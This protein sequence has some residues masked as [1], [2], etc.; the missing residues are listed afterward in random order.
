MSD[1][2]Q[3]VEIIVSAN[4]SV[5]E[6][7]AGPQGPP[8][9]D[10]WLEPVQPLTATG[11]S[12]LIDYSAGKHVRLTLSS[13]VTLAISNWPVA[14]RIARLT[15]EIHSTGTFSITWPAEVKWP[16]DAMPVLTPSATDIIILT[17]TTSGSVIYGFPAG[18][19]FN[20]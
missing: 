16:A 10:P 15:L 19:S 14:D 3:I 5:I 6:I 2:P 9:P 18:L 1:Q 13:D 12:L 11:A 7:D 20:G 17:T 4:P 8:G